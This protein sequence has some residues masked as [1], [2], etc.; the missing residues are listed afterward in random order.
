LLLGLSSFPFQSFFPLFLLQG[1]GGLCYGQILHEGFSA[2]EVLDGH[3]FEVLELDGALVVRVED[4][5]EGGDVVLIGVV[6]CMDGQL[7]RLM[8]S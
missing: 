6:G 5:D 8:A 7:R 2:A 4:A 3:L 1:R